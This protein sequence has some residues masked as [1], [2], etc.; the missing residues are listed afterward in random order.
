[1]LSWIEENYHPTTI[2][3][4]CGDPEWLE[5]WLLKHKEF[6]PPI[7]KKLRFLPK[8]TRLDH[9]KNFLGIHQKLYDFVVFG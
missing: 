5:S 1:L 2:T 7:F 4:A 9:I 3:I 6:F 8:A